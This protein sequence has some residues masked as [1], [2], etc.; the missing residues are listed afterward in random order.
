M[1][2]PLSSLFRTAAMVT[3][4]LLPPPRVAAFL[5]HG[6]GASL[7]NGHRGHARAGKQHGGTAAAVADNDDDSGSGGD[8]SNRV[9]I[10][11]GGFGGLYTALRLSQLAAAGGQGRDGGGDLSITVVDNRDKFVFLPLLYELAT[12]Q[13]ELEEVAPRM[14]DVLKGTGIN[15]VKGRIG[16]LD[17]GKRTVAVAPADVETDAQLLPYDRLV[18]ALGSQPRNLE[19]IPGAQDNSIPF[20]TVE[21]AYRMQRELARLDAMVDAAETRSKCI[22]V[23]VV[24]GGCVSSLNTPSHMAVA[25]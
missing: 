21:D 17:L 23:V 11:G 2:G 19:T 15:F 3:L 7:A 9:V 25:I 12:G 6:A 18:V 14:E 20:Y 4:S 10:L 24:G 22:N 16:E 5:R 8:A 13:A 1:K